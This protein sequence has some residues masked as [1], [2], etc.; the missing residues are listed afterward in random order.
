MMILVGFGRMFS[1]GSKENLIFTMVICY[2]EYVY[3]SLIVLSD[4]RLLWSCMQNYWD[5]TFSTLKTITFVKEHFYWSR[6]KFC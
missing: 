2:M 1:W 5:D 6:Y 4:I 3:V